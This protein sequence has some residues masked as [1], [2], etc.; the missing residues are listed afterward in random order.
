MKKDTLKAGTI[1]QCTY[2]RNSFLLIVLKDNKPT[3][4]DKEFG[5]IYNF[6]KDDLFN[7]SKLEIVFWPHYINKLELFLSSGEIN[8]NY[9]EFR[10]FCQ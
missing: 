3:S 2:G 8:L 7:F 9:I 6:T 5:P 10:V 1:I 4:Y